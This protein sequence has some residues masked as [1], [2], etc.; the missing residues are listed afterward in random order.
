MLEELV[1]DPEFHAPLLAALDTVGSAKG[2]SLPVQAVLSA[3][4][5]L[6]AILDIADIK[7]VGG[8]FPNLWR[9]MLDFAQ[10]PETDVPDWLHF[11]VPSKK[12]RLLGRTVSVRKS[13]VPASTAVEASRLCGEHVGTQ[14]P[15]PKL[16]V[17]SSWE[18]IGLR[19]PRAVATKLVCIVKTKRDGSVKIRL[20]IDF[21]CSGVN[22][23][24]HVP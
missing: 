18:A 23:L 5:R 17:Y 15:S 2:W 9:S 7:S 12:S 6:H 11:G 3:R 19:W 10:D 20:V 22:G 1:N 13:T 21:R 24:T 4:A 16:R 8:Y 14:H